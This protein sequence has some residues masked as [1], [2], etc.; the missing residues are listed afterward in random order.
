MWGK[1]DER[2]AEGRGTVSSLETK[3]GVFQRGSETDEFERSLLGVD[4][5]LQG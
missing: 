1:G 4:S 3:M 2:V 5:I